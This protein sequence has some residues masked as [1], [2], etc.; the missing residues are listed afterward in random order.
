MRRLVLSILLVVSGYVLGALPPSTNRL[1]NDFAGVFTASQVSTMESRLED[2]SD[3]M[4]NQIC[5]VT[6]STLDGYEA[7]DYAQRLGQKWGVGSANDNGV[8]IL[9]KPRSAD[10]KYIDVFI[11]T[12][13]GIEGALTDA[14]C[15]RIIN[16]QMAPFLKQDTP[17][18]YGAVEAAVDE[19]IPIMQ[20]EYNEAMDYGD[21]E[22]LDDISTFMGV[23]I[24]LVSIGLIIAFF[25]TK[26]RRARSALQNAATPEEFAKYV[27]NA[28]KVGIPVDWISQLEM[29]MP[30]RTLQAVRDARSTTGLN[31]QKKRA[32]AFGNSQDAINAAAAIALAAMAAAFVAASR[33]RRSS[34]FGGSSGSFGGSSGGHSF[35][36]FGG[37]SFGG[38]GAGGRF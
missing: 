7:A 19:I 21:D 15:K 25:P 13:Y 18:Y 10:E 6:V 20:G 16:N 24:L 30:R 23:L 5:I 29:D 1:V 17:D 2:F 31:Y 27:P 14:L 22:D 38:G 26:K 9:L 28:I 8:L 11:A 35:G 33:G 4:S 37:G 34:G 12:G 3:N 32:A 36:G